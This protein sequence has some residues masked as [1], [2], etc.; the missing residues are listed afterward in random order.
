MTG[1]GLFVAFSLFQPPQMRKDSELHLEFGSGLP[2]ALFPD[3]QT[4]LIRT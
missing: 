1:K 3:V 2:V 4:L